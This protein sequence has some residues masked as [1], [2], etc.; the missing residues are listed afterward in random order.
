MTDQMSPAQGSA[1]AQL[2]QL[3]KERMNQGVGLA[4]KAAGQQTGTVAQGVRQAGEEMRQQGQESHGKVADQV[5][6]PVQ[7]LSG[8]LSTA[9]PQELTGSVKQAKPKLG[10]QARQLKTQAGSQ[11]TRQADVRSTQAGQG[12]TA[13]TQGVRQT[14]QQLRAQGQEVPA[15]V[16]DALAEKVEPLG[17]YLTTADA[18]KLRSDISAKGRQAKT[19]LSSA[20]GTVAR[21][22]QT[23]IAKGADA[24]KQTASGVRRSPVLPIVGALAGSVLAARRA[25]KGGSPS[26]PSSGGTTQSASE[27]DLME[28]SRA[29]LQ[30]RAA[31]AGVAT[32]PGMTKSQLI[33]AMRNA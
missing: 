24:A 31:E 9:D 18:D 13:L 11:L 1:A 17:G 22:Q 4:A 28:L 14:G 2:K 15:L 20:A 6:Q 3:L 30:Q 32:E 33:E 8:S 23:A 25:A 29:Q 7:R 10:E 12:V 27:S 16:L 5:A 26:A 21:K 19:K